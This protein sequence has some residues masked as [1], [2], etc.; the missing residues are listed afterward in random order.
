MAKKDDDGGVFPC[1][2]GMRLVVAC[3]E[4]LSQVTKVPPMKTNDL[5]ETQRRALKAS[6]NP[7]CMKCEEDEN[8]GKLRKD[9]KTLKEAFRKMATLHAFDETKT[10]YIFVN[11]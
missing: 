9:F 1:S 4:S 2:E 5:R 10:P 8:N 3:N 11:L 6:K 7:Y